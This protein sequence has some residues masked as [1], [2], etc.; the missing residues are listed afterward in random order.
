MEYDPRNKRYLFV[1]E[2]YEGLIILIV[3]WVCVATF[4]AFPFDPSQKFLVVSLH[5]FHMSP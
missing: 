3:Y 5:P 2:G 1:G 4:L